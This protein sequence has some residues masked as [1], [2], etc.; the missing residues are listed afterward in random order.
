MQELQQRLG[1]INEARDKHKKAGL[2][3]HDRGQGCMDTRR[4]AQAA[5]AFKKRFEAEKALKELLPQ[6]VCGCAALSCCL[7]RRS[8][9]PCTQ[10]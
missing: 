2:L 6:R 4:H 9:S 5:V 3:A 8:T 1:V 7:A 10:P